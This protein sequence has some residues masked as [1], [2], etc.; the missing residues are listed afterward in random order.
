MEKTKTSGYPKKSNLDK[1]RFLNIA[2]GSLDECRY[3]VI[4]SNDLKYV[5]NDEYLKLDNQGESVVKLLQAYINK[6]TQ[7]TS[8]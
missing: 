3:Y 2:Q 7:N 4:L 6:I 5:T 8:K 1:L